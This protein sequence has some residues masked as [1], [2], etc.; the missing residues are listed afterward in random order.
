MT[1]N[2]GE[3]R[4]S[5]H[6][7][8][9]VHAD[10]SPRGH[11][12]VGRPRCARFAPLRSAPRTVPPCWNCVRRWINV[13]KTRLCVLLLLCTVASNPGDDDGDPRRHNTA[14]R[15]A[16]GVLGIS[17]KNRNTRR[18]ERLGTEAIAIRMSSRFPSVRYENHVLLRESCPGG[19]ISVAV[20]Q[21]SVNFIFAL[22]LVTS[23][24]KPDLV[25]TCA[26]TI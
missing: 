23:I 24:I 10:E 12:P 26:E 1:A 2:A 22:S 21:W 18:F 17:W 25:S 8:A 19:K 5:A 9:C 11:P 15:D 3:E 16:R 4:Y 7:H 6:V 20:V 14:R 13:P